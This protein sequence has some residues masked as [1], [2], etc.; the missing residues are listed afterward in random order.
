MCKL[1]QLSRFRTGSFYVEITGRR[2]VCRWKADDMFLNFEEKSVGICGRPKVWRKKWNSKKKK[3]ETNNI[4]FNLQLRK[5]T[6]ENFW[7]WK[8]KMSAKGRNFAALE[9]MQSFL[10]NPFATTKLAKKCAA[11][12]CVR[13]LPTN[14]TLT[15]NSVGYLNCF[16]T[17]HS[18]VLFSK[19]PP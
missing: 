6:N 16:T 12:H 5:E 18:T 11:E 17:R 3:W 4:A 1:P 13:F 9:R 7:E 19:L 15:C 14:E 10:L 8:W 2:K